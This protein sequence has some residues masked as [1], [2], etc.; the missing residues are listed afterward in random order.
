MV[1]GRMIV[2]FLKTYFKESVA[3]VSSHRALSIGLALALIFGGWFLF[4]SRNNGE[5]TLT[6]YG[7]TVA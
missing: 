2:S 4:G 1:F 5:E 7:A 3:F 6:G